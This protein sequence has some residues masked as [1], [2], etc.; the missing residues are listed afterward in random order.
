[1]KAIVNKMIAGV[2][3]EYPNILILNLF[4]AY[5]RCYLPFLRSGFLA[6]IVG[7]VLM[8]KIKN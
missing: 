8:P 1:M 7:F 6:Y 3:A 4:G 2:C 5:F